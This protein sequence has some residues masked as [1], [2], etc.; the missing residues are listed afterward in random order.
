MLCGLAIAHFHI[1]RY[2][3]WRHSSNDTSTAQSVDRKST[4]TWCL[5]GASAKS[6]RSSPRFFSMR[7]D[8]RHRPAQFSFKTQLNIRCYWSCCSPPPKG[9]CN[10][11]LLR[12]TTAWR[13]PVVHGL[14]IVMRYWLA[15]RTSVLMEWPHHFL[16][17][18]S[19]GRS[20][21]TLQVTVQFHIRFDALSINLRL[22]TDS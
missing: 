11:W 21:S 7:P 2:T 13:L 20:S 16:V 14:P 12:D 5:Y 8:V 17:L 3:H 1:C 6:I 15:S 9:S 22:I 19:F 18:L 10:S 4:A